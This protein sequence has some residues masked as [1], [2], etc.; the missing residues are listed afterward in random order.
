MSLIY[1]IQEVEVVASIRVTNFHSPLSVCRV[2]KL[3]GKQPQMAVIKTSFDAAK[4]LEKQGWKGKGT[5]KSN[6]RAANAVY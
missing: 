4:H 6:L 3:Y 1:C 5:G 2:Y